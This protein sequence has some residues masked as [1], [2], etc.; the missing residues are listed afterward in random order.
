MLHATIHAAGPQGQTLPLA[1]TF[2]EAAAALEGLPRLYFEPDG[3]F[4]WVSEAPDV[5]WQI[6][7][8]LQDRGECLDHVVIKGTCAPMAF[9]QLLNILRP[10]S[11]RLTFQLIGQSDFVDEAKAEQ[12][13]TP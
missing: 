8:Q 5:P 3:S 6:D 7:G 11:Q 4:L 13:V 12:L 2:E 1:I 9:A 10:T